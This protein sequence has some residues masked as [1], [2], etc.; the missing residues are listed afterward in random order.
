[1]EKVCTS[2]NLSKACRKQEELGEWRQG[3]HGRVLS[4]AGRGPEPGLSCPCPSDSSMEALTLNLT[5]VVKRQN[6]KSKKGFNQVRTPLLSAAVP[7]GDPGAGGCGVL[8]W[9]RVLCTDVSHRGAL[10]LLLGQLGRDRAG[11][12]AGPQGG[13]G[14][15]PRLAVSPA[16][17]LWG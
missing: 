12:E 5:E 6:P 7:L 8:P 11:E 14:P 1:M 13:W 15:W 2:V 10:G 17:L 16:K 4:T 3:A 9:S